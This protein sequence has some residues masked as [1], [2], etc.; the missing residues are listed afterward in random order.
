VKSASHPHGGNIDPRW[1]TRKAIIG[2]AEVISAAAQ[3]TD[4]SM[5]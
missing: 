2:G 1:N 5:P 3:I 4:Q